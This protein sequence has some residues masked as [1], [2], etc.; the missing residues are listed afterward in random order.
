MSTKTP[1]SRE[2][3]AW[4]RTQ[5]CVVT[6]ARINVEAAHVRMGNGGG[7]GIKPSD[8]RTLPLSADQHRRQH[9]VGE[10]AF[11]AA[12]G[13]SPDGLIISHMVRYIGDPKTVMSILER[14]I[15]AGC[16]CKPLE[17]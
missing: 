10:K 12:L 16:D 9:Q 8:F 3:L 15:T 1:R 17:D 2:Y 6:G 4:I 11:W 13:I 7:M 14:A 5:P